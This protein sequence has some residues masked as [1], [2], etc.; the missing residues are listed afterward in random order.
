MTRDRLARMRR[1]QRA[2][3]DAHCDIDQIATYPRRLGILGLTT[4]LNGRKNSLKVTSRAAK[5]AARASTVTPLS[6]RSSL[7]TQLWYADHSGRSGLGD[8]LSWRVCLAPS[9]KPA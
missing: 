2:W 7:R 3:Y 4:S 9:D 5:I 1:D 8:A 6:P